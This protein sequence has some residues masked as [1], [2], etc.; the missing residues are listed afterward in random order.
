M[1]WFLWPFFLII[2]YFLGKYYRQIFQRILSIFKSTLSKKWMISITFFSYFLSFC[3][4]NI[5]SSIGI[6]LLHFLA[7]SLLFEGIYWGIKKVFHE[8]KVCKFIYQSS[9]IPIIITGIIFGYGFIHIRDIVETSYHITSSKKLQAP[10]RI[11]FLAD[12][13]YGTVLDSSSLTQLKERLNEE[14]VDLVILG[15]DIVDENTTKEEM[16]EIFLVLGNV[17]STYGT[18][19]VYGNHDRQNYS[20]WKDFSLVELEKTLQENHIVALK[21]EM[22]ELR[23]DLVL[24]GRE[25][26]SH[27]RQN[28]ESILSKVDS[29][30]Y[31]ILIDHQPVEYENN[32]RLGIDLMLSGHT[33]AGQVF[34]AGYFIRWLHLADLWYGYKRENSMDAIVTSGLAGWGYP[35]RT[36]EN[37]E[38]VIIDIK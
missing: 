26:K 13:H 8:N 28:V 35:I 23:N 7:L 14:E 19:F 3:T 11:L 29:S 30:K 36:Q 5:F 21:D 31:I 10:L 9:V 32:S 25:D 33:H 12:A 27:K 17:K 34:P 38:Y 15:G 22:V 1:H 16:K 37:S 6:F 4:I 2:I 20:S 24:V 18:Y